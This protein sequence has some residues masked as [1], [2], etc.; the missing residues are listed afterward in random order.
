M[1]TNRSRT[2]KKDSEVNFSDIQRLIIEESTKRATETARIEAMLLQLDRKFEN[3]IEEI[4]MGMRQAQSAAEIALKRCNSMDNIIEETKQ[5]LILTNSAV[6]EIEK[7]LL[8]LQNE[9]EDVHERSLRSTLVIKG[10]RE[11]HEKTWDDTRKVV[12]NFLAKSC[13][14]S[15]DYFDHHIERAHRSKATGETNIRPVFIKFTDWRVAEE[16][17]LIRP[18]SQDGVFITQLHTPRLTA[19]INAALLER[20]KLRNGEGNTWK[21]Y[22]AHPA[23]LMIKR[24]TDRTYL[25]HKVF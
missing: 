2:E 16:V 6:K 21:M 9:L 18:R 5:D 7:N 10:L 14:R 17:R 8:S 13:N 1:A 25:V 19:R 12:C 22:V 4:K 24:P 20:K 23:K 15:E 3:T 11:S